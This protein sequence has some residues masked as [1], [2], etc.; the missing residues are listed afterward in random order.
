VVIGIPQCGK[1]TRGKKRF[2]LPCK[3]D[4]VLLAPARMTRLWGRCCDHAP[5][6]G[7]GSPSRD[8]DRVDEVPLLRHRLGGIPEG[9]DRLGRPQTCGRGERREGLGCGWGTGNGKAAWERTS[10]GRQE[11]GGRTTCSASKCG[12]DTFVSHSGDRGLARQLSPTGWLGVKALARTRHQMELWVPERLLGSYHG[13]TLPN[14]MVKTL[15]I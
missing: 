4:Q 5:T 3:T 8:R 12:I 9:D 7:G 10:V 11:D 1:K 14:T 13:T 2:R 6:A 15:K